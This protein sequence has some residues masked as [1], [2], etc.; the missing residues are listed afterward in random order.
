[1]ELKEKLAR[2]R[3]S[4]TNQIGAITFYKL[5]ER[6]GSAE[7][8]LKFLPEL[9]RKGGRLKDIEIFSESSALQE[10]ERVEKLGGQIIA[11][12]EPEYPYMLSQIE[13]APPVISV[14]GNA[15]IL[16]KP[17]LGVVGARNASMIGRK[18]CT[19]FCDRVSDAGFV[20]TSGLAR[21]IDTAAHEASLKGG[22]VAVVAGGIDVIYP[23]E[24]EKLYK[25]IIE[26]D[27]AIVAESPFG[28]EPLARHFPK[29]NRIISGLSLGVLIVEAAL[30]SGSLITANNALEQNREVFAVPGS[31]KD[32]RAEGTNKLI[33][34]GAHL[35]DNANDI[36]MELEALKARPMMDSASSTFAPKFEFADIKQE[37]DFDEGIYQDIID[38]LTY[39]PIQIDEII[40][41]TGYLASHVMTAILELELEGRVERHLGNKISLA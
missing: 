22:T 17:S 8:A 12:G 9:A 39:S 40:R 11:N 1:M 2:I 5:L 19:E 24:N 36:I 18:I 3:L 27:G 32:P 33:K 41:D 34:E 37:L 26:N 38:R 13:D 14:L 7:N 25:A 30:K 4:R 35:A 20:I 16:S 15:E 31:P 23:P 6:Y 10:I 29:R 28:V 21:G